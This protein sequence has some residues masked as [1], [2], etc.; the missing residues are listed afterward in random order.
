MAIKKKGEDEEFLTVGWDSEFQEQE[1]ISH[2]LYIAE[3]GEEIFI[4][5]LK[6]GKTGITFN[7]LILRIKDKHP[8]VEHIT[9]IS[10]FSRAELASILDGRDIVFKGGLIYSSKTLSG[11]LPE[12]EGIK[13]S[14][15]DT[16]KFFPMALSDI[17]ELI[18]IPKVDI[19]KYKKDEM[20]VLYKKNFKLFRKYAMTDAIIAVKAYQRLIE[21]VEKENMKVGQTIGG[22]GE[23]FLRERLIEA[24]KNTPDML[25][26][27]GYEPDIQKKKRG[28]RIKGLRT[29]NTIKH[30]FVNV[31]FG[32]RNE[33]YIKA[34]LKDITAYD[35]DLVSAYVSMQ[36]TM[37][38]WDIKKPKQFT[39]PKECFE[40]LLK[41][42]FAHGFVK[43]SFISHNG[44]IQYPILPVKN[45][46]ILVFVSSARNMFM[47]AREFFVAYNDFDTIKGFTATIYPT[48]KDNS[49][50]SDFMR[51]MKERRNEYK[52]KGD[53]LAEQTFKLIG[54]S[55][56]GK[57]TQG[58][59]GK[60]V[61]NLKSLKSEFIPYSSVSNPFLSSY[62]T[63]G[64]RAIAYE[65]LKELQKINQRVFYFTTDGFA[66]DKEIP[67]SIINGEFGIWSKA[68]SDKLVGLT[69]SKILLELKHKGKGW[70]SMKTRGYAMLEKVEDADIEDDD[71]DV[72]FSF[73]SMQ[74]K[75]KT[76]EEKI[77][78]ILGEVS[79][80]DRFKDT[81][82][83]MTWITPLRDWL[84]GKPY[85]T[86]T[87]EQSFNYDFDFKR[88]P[89]KVMYVDGFVYHETKPYS[90]IDEFLNYRELY[91]DF[92]KGKRIDTGDKTPQGDKKYK[93][94]GGKNKLITVEHYRQFFEYVMLRNMKIAGIERIN[95]N[96]VKRLIGSYMR[97]ERGFTYKKIQDG[98]GLKEKGARE[99][100][101]TKIDK[102]Y[103]KGLLEFMRKWIKFEESALS[104][105]KVPIEPQ[106]AVEF[107]YAEDYLFWLMLNGVKPESISRAM[108]ELVDREK[109]PYAKTFRKSLKTLIDFS[110]CMGVIKKDYSKMIKIDSKRMKQLQNHP[111][112]NKIKTIKP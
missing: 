40:F 86:Q 110:N 47:T 21:I 24:Y 59:S 32:G 97:H 92:M 13:I 96:T 15:L 51:D 67:K 55:T 5:L 72:L 20:K 2:Q 66:T 94:I 22:I 11:R 12:V 27:L 99:A 28:M 90:D 101:D 106:K 65:I 88:L 83:P 54:N 70:I 49:I 105:D 10:H 52:K 64:I 36:T 23:R 75:G 68:V 84:N 63:G 58:Y 73:S 69:G 87:R 44:D 60:R 71:K 89:E 33:T 19:G 77:T 26:G 79:S 42:I 98:L 112:L 81:T 50:V 107:E 18:G 111:D 4:D 17:G 104:A 8:N 45:E 78:K 95:E 82:Y 7:E 1:I 61:L 56:Y 41:D 31:L 37:P 102:K 93:Q 29:A 43:A 109:S 57:F 76:V 91:H 74:F 39:N 34:L 38:T 108:L 3:T 14:L 48:V 16:M 30:D 80:L 9:L 25:Y 62:V 100:S 6:E 85:T 103:E 53:R 35:Y 46:N